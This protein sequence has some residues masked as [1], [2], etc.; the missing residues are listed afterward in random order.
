MCATTSGNDA[1]TRDG[2]FGNVLIHSQHIQHWAWLRTAPVSLDDGVLTIGDQPS[3]FEFERPYMRELSRTLLGTARDGARVLDIGVG[4]GVFMSEVLQLR[5]AWYIGLELNS[6]LVSRARLLA[7]REKK[8]TTQIALFDL[9]WQRYLSTVGA[10]SDA[11]LLDTFPP[12]GFGEHDFENFVAQ[13]PRLLLTDGSLGFVRIGP[14]SDNASRHS[15]LQ[16]LFHGFTSIKVDA[17]F[18]KSWPH[19]SKELTFYAYTK[20]VGP[21]EW[22][23]S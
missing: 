21:M 17:K 9:P 12:P 15:L 19:E 13:L 1:R 18:P 22:S 2:T 8:S 20:Y 6:E 10:P 11:I 4:A 23:D 3:M 5:P 16:S 14:T 7:Q